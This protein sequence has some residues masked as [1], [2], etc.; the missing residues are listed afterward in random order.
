MK[1][2]VKLQYQKVGALYK[3]YERLLMPATLLGGFLIDY[4]TFTSI[5]IRTTFIILFIYWI[6]AGSII[7]FMHLFDAGKVNVW[8]RLKY[9][10]L[11]SPLILQFCFGSLLG[12]SLIFYWF[13]GA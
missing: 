2:F 4:I 7:A 9:L 8:Y 6:L 1:T 10:R 3:K 12:S 11:F 5:N 13:S